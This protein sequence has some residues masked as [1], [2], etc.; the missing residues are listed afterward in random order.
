MRL[1]PG[2]TMPPPSS[3]GTARGGGS[4]RAS[5]LAPDNLPHVG[6][7]AGISAAQPHPRVKIAPEARVRV[8]WGPHLRGRTPARLR[9]REWP[10]EKPW[11]KAE[12]ETGWDTQRLEEQKRGSGGKGDRKVKGGETAS[13]EIQ[14]EGEVAKGSGEHREGVWRGERMQV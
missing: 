2:Q 4:P 9:E 12:G 11:H 10:P 3:L 14:T 1:R 6:P 8:R 7:R 5:P 13:Q